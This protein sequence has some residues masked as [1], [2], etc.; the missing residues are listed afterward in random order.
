MDSEVLERA[1]ENFRFFSG[2]IIKQADKKS[3]TYECIETNED[4]ISFFSEKTFPYNV[5]DSSIIGDY[6]YEQLLIF[7]IRKDLALNWKY[8][9]I[10]DFCI[11]LRK[12]INSDMLLTSDVYDDICLIEESGIIWSSTF[13]LKEDMKNCEIGHTNLGL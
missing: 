13:P 9:R 8:E 11:Y 6:V 1:I 12:Q 5:Y 7:D 4:V 2:K 3:I 10:I